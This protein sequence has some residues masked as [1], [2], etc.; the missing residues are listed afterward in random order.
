LSK[1]A[2]AYTLQQLQTGKVVQLNDLEDA[3]E[4]EAVG[5]GE[6]T[7]RVKSGDQGEVF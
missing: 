2:V 7:I 4:V 1:H 5:F 6:E 3:L